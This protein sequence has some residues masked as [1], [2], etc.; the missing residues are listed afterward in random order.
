MQFFHPSLRALI[1]IAATIALLAG[2]AKPTQL[3]EIL[4]RGELRV[5]TRPGPTTY[6]LGAHG[7]GGLDY[8]LA[9]QLAGELGVRLQMIPLE[10]NADVFE[11]LKAGR[12]DIAAAHLTPPALLD[13]TL[14]FGQPLFYSQPV[15]IHRS[16]TP[17][18]TALDDLGD[19]AISVLA[20]SAEVAVLRKAKT[21]HPALR[22][23]EVNLGLDELLEVISN[24][25]VGF[26]LADENLVA[27]SLAM[28]PSIRLGLKVGAPQPV[29]WAFR[30]VAEDDSLQLTTERFFARLRATASL[31]KQ[32]QRYQRGDR[33]QDVVQDFF[34]LRH[35][36]ERLPRYLPMFERAAAKHDL[37]WRVLAAVGYQESHWNPLARSPTG[38]R[39]LMM[40][41]RDTAAR[42][43][44]KD[45]LNAEESI[46]GGARYLREML[47]QVPERIGM[48]D[49][50]YF[51]LA[52][53]NIGIG[54][55]EDARRLTQY[56][57]GN[58]DRWEDVRA[59]LPLLSR[60]IWHSKTRLG[61]APGGQAVEFVQNVG[62]YLKTLEWQSN[63][64]NFA[65][66]FAKREGSAKADAA[67]G[68]GP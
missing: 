40:L 14:R 20:R 49:R 22:W 27:A 24:E 64:A 67:G 5:L 37:D 11:A 16:S 33:E 39:G 66:R 34:F 52:A 53:Y 60:A 26:A 31:D 8:E 56:R 41:T 7:A 3:E 55:F 44:V 25:E 21:K 32:I 54:H 48:P 4:A 13:P 61:R 29:A 57:G 35:L 59:T 50:L 36:E 12:G 45:R 47:N 68:A 62:D 43:G 58:P 15:L 18:P 42:L 63:N 17:A 9:Q 65:A 46:F 1:V 30:H 19:E 51:A 10:R 23:R 6:F 38:V 28:Y 2:C